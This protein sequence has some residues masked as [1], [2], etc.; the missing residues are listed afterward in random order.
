MGTHP[1]FESDFDCLTEK[2]RLTKNSVRSS[3]W[4]RNKNRI[5]QFQTGSD[6]VLVTPSSTTLRDVTGDVPR[7]DCKSD[8][9][10]KFDH[11]TVNDHVSNLPIMLEL[12]FIIFCYL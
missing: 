2:W 6:T 8:Q 7:S 3:F 10:E 9:Y 11:V 5:D 1:I 12:Q 4:L